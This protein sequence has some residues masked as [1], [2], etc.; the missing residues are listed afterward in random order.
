M[1]S[2]G[3]VAAGLGDFL[4]ARRERLSPQDLGLP[5]HGRRRTQGLR[6]EEVAVLAG[7]SIDYYTRLEQGRDEH[8]SW[9]IVSAMAD[10]LRLS[11]D[12]RAHLHLLAGLPAPTTY[13]S[14]SSPVRSSV[15]ALLETL[16]PAP[17]S[18]RPSVIS[19]RGTRPL[20]CCGSTR[21]GWRP[22]SAISPG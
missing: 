19:W 14:P 15:S 10:A 6:R 20:R 1:A 11:P 7:A 3:K 9:S 5:V 17:A 18:S 16:M 22:T 4:R 21:R 2:G 8:P 13:V 12:E